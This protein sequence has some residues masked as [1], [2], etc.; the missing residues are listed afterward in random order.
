LPT[1]RAAEAGSPGCRRHE[2]WI[3]D[4]LANTHSQKFDKK[5]GFPTSAPVLFAPR[6]DANP[7]RA[8]RWGVAKLVKAPDFD[9]G[10]RRFESFFPSQA[11]FGQVTSLPDFHC[12]GQMRD[13]MLKVRRNVKW[14]TTA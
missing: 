10:I 12:V 5:A 3:A 1:A 13:A 9:S 8:T 4:G 7:F 2:G 6:S 11:S 14:P